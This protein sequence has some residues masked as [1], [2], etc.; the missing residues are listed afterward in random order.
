MIDDAQQ[1]AK[2]FIFATSM[3][4]CH[5]NLRIRQDIPACHLKRSELD[6]KFRKYKRRIVLRGDAVKDDSGSYAAFIEQGTSAS[7]MT[8]ANVLDVI[9]RPPD[10]GSE[11][12]DVVSAY[13]QVKMED[14]PNIVEITGG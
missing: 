4:L 2:Q 3:D 5:F 10:G 7:L 6:N 13:A 12:S 9:S 11:A 8:T 1:K 14:V